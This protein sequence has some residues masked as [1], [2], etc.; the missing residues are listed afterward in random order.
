[1]AER[2]DLID[3]IPE[4][5]PIPGDDVPDVPDVNDPLTPE[6]PDVKRPL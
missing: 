4:D 2:P 5:E 6:D 3:P 1:M